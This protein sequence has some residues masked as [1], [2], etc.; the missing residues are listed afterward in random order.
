M[1]PVVIDRDRG[2]GQGVVGEGPRGHDDP[3]IVHPVDCCAAITTE[4]KGHRRAGVSGPG[5]GLGFSTDGHIRLG[6][7]SLNSKGTPCAFLA[8]DT[9][10]HRHSYR[11][12]VAFQT[13]SL[14]TAGGGSCD[15]DRLLAVLSDFPV[16]S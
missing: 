16:D 1:A 12:A 7:A 3:F 11:F 10:A 4:M 5:V 9:V 8:F 6:K 14:A 2:L 13:D 15:H